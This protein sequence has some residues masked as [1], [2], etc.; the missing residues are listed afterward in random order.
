MGASIIDKITMPEAKD[1]FGRL[2]QTN[3]YNITLDLP[4]QVELYLRD[5]FGDYRN[6]KKRFN[7][8]CSDTSLPTSSFA[9]GEVK[10]NYMGIPQEFAHTRIYNDIDFTFYIDDDYSALKILDGWM[11]FISGG[12]QDIRR[13][14][15][16]RFQYPNTYKTD[17]LYVTKFEKD[18]RTNALT[19]KF[20]NAFPK[21]ITPIPISYGSADILK[22]TV[23]F[24][25]DRYV[26]GNIL[27]QSQ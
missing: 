13:N 21:T 9:T 2:S 11:D 6:F 19:Y 20:I 24:N 10:D 14:A 16:R 8:L 27:V 22:V 25:F 26:M 17:T 18:I 5:T 4:Y 3:Q 12:Q 7:L 23:S 1:F 15:F